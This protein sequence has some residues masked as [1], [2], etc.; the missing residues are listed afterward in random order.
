[1]PKNKRKPT[2][3]RGLNS[4]EKKEVV[5]LAK[6][7]TLSVAEKKF[8]NPVGMVAEDPHY[9][10]RFGR[11]SVRAA[12]TTTN[13]IGTGITL[14]YGMIPD[15]NDPNQDI[16]VAMDELKML[17]PYQDTGLG[18]STDTYAIEGREIM[19]SVAQCKW[20]LSRNISS[21]IAQLTADAPEDPQLAIPATLA[22]NLPVL[23]RMIRVTP[24]MSQTATVCDPEQDLFSSPQTNNH[25]GIANAA[26]DDL[27]L[28]TFP[29]N[30]RRY[31]V[32][33]DKKFKLQNGL[34]VGYQ[35]SRRFVSTGGG[36]GAGSAD[37][38]FQP[39]ITNT[40]A[41]CERVVTTRHQLSNKKGGKIFYD[42]ATP[43]LTVDVNNATTGMRKEFTLWHFMYMG[44]ESY[45][46][47]A[48]AT[49]RS[50]LDL[51]ISAVPLVKF[52][53]V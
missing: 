16:G 15:P 43:T 53:D 8:M 10:N 47:D 32:L 34:T 20:R 49:I 36:T 9:I 50:P 13:K 11:I 22:T 40:N 52:S 6:K 14:N 17:R 7:A 30:R 42:A 24:K 37:A 39:V 23:C 33:E 44:A 19:P 12:V 45:L 1:M 31:T 48:N 3:P 46:N 4:K 51:K 41:N 5:K 35:A 29:I 26:F 25:I 18:I 28:M 38:F 21:Q 27:E 2:K